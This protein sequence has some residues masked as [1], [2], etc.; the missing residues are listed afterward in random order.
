MEQDWSKYLNMSKQ[1]G[2]LPSSLIPIVIAIAPL[3]LKRRDK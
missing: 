1:L 2:V 3:D